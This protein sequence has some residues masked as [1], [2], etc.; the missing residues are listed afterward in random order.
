MSPLLFDLT[1]QIVEETERRVLAFKSNGTLP[2]VA[3]RHAIFPIPFL[4]LGIGEL[5]RPV[6]K[7][8]I[9]S[10]VLL[11]AAFIF[12]PKA[13]IP[14]DAKSYIFMFCTYAPIILVIFAVPSTF[15]FDSISG[16]Q[17]NG[18]ADYIYS[19]GFNSEEKLAS[20]DESISLVAERAY[21]RTQAFQR[22]VAVIWGLFLFG[23]S[24]FTSIALKIAPEQST[25]IFSDNMSALLLYGVVS[26]LSIVVIIGY[27]KANDAVFRRLQF[28]IQELKYRVAEN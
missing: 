4:Q 26:L 12:V 17:V 7:W 9:I 21:A 18:L 19:L 28:S 16:T 1:Q 14:A 24:Q 10:V 15:V 11:I 13:N 8:A 27:K 25:R 3:S 5:M 2:D 20:L 23:L 6:F 22:L